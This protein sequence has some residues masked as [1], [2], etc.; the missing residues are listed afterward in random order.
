M[1]TDTTDH[2]PTTCSDCY[3]ETEDGAG[4]FCP[5]CIYAPDGEPPDDFEDAYRAHVRMSG[6]APPHADGSRCACLFGNSGLW[7]RIDAGSPAESLYQEAYAE[8]MALMKPV[9]DEVRTED[10]SQSMDPYDAPCV[11]YFNDVLTFDA[12]M[13]TL[14]KVAP[15]IDEV[16]RE[17]AYSDAREATVRPNYC[18]ADE[19]V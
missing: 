3:H 8:Y 2:D 11:E 4:C 15:L 7:L 1:T 19:V 5:N 9:W 18:D 12:R 14:T 6:T 13:R 17:Y 16:V 10:W